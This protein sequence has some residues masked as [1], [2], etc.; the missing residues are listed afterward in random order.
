MEWKIPLFKTYSDQDDI[1]SVTEVIR[2][3][4]YWA[5]GPE[6][7][8]FEKKI[9]K[10][11]EAKYCTVLN[12]GT[13]ALHAALLVAGIKAGDEVIVPSFTFI[14]TANAP[15]FIGAKPVFC[16]IEQDVLGLDSEKLK[17]CITPKT[18]AIIPVNYAG[19][20][21]DI[22]SII[23]IAK[24]N[25][26]LVIEDAAEAMGTKSGHKHAG[27]F[28]TMGIYSFCQNKIISTGEGGCIITDDSILDEKLK[29]LRSHGREERDR[30]YFNG[31]SCNYG[32]LGYN[33]R[34]P[35]INAA[36]GI[37]QLNKI[38]KIIKSRR[39]IASKYN[40]SFSSL[41]IEIPKERNGI[42]HVYQLYTIRLKDKKTRDNLQNYLKLRGISSKIY[43]PPV[44]K[45]KTFKGIDVELPITDSVSDTVLSLPIYP[46]LKNSETEEIINIVKQFF[47]D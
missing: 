35:S 18:K 32:S 19:N 11:S 10:Y 44:H 42:R 30:N 29:I 23:D 17:E 3:G 37:S 8:E 26:I 13:S 33:F 25:N 36:L 21:C 20:L 1:D 46:T 38:E 31:E 28:G 41:D 15:R 45:E 4:T 16:D 39:E 5:V 47:G 40:N 24:D 6:I 12:N 2:R 27:T 7:E 43:F 9:C 34:M 14:S 22:E